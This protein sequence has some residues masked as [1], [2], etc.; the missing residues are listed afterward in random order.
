MNTLMKVSC[1]I[2]R[3]RSQKSNNMVMPHHRYVTTWVHDPLM[4]R[5]PP[6]IMCT[7]PPETVVS[8]AAASRPD[9]GKPSSLLL[10]HMSGPAPA[11]PY[12]RPCLKAPS[13][14]G[15]HG[16]FSSQVERAMPPSVGTNPDNFHAGFP[17]PAE[18]SVEHVL[19]WSLML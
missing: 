4:R 18:S 5:Y 1:K 7:R 13:A 12:D 11:H 15:S 3:K 6:W 2:G 17:E 14:D 16:V 10:R 19:P 9:S 8:T